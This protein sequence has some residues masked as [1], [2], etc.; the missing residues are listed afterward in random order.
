VTT[1]SREKVPSSVLQALFDLYIDFVPNQMEEL[2][3]ELA[4]HK[5]FLLD[6]FRFIVQRGYTERVNAIGL[7][8]FRDV[9]IE[10]MKKPISLN[11]V[12]WLNGVRLK[13]FQ[14]EDQYNRLKEATTI[15]ELALWKYKMDKS[16]TKKKMKRAEEPDLD[17]RA[18]CRVSCNADMVIEQVLPYL[19]PSSLPE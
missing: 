19:L 2:F 17:F 5:D 16:D 18:Q 10:E 15:L 7:K 14:C 3:E 12:P 6:K 1:L 9:M 4:E 11:K 13:F 8:K